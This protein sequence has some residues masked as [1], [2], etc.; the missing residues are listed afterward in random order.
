[1]HV[2]LDESVWQMS[3]RVDVCDC[4]SAGEESSGWVWASLERVSWH[5]PWSRASQR[6][7]RNLS[8]HRLVN[9]S[10]STDCSIILFVHFTEFMQQPGHSDH[11]C[12]DPKITSFC[13]YILI[14]DYFFLVY[15]YYFSFS[16]LSIYFQFISLVHQI[17]GSVSHFCLVHLL[18]ILFNLTN[19]FFNNFR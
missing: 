6:R 10:L 1:M 18:F 19:I 9:F 7:V 16:Y 4:V 5:M 11:I 8:K 15:F 3:N 14:L 17:N 13:F 12:Q 2:C